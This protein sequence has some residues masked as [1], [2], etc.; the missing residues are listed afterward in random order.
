MLFSCFHPWLHHIQY[1]CLSKVAQSN[2]I[3]DNAYACD[4]RI[5]KFKEDAK[6]KKQREKDAKREAARKK[7]EEE[8][9]VGKEP[10]GARDWWH[11]C[12]ILLTVLLITVTRYWLHFMCDMFQKKQE[13]LEEERRRKQQQEDEAKAKVTHPHST[14]FLHAHKI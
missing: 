8:E 13:V 9:K 1:S 11:W 3:A 6:Q 14:E 12:H 4:P 10:G 2:S 5:A 7:Q